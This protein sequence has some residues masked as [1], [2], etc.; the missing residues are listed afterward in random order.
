MRKEQRDYLRR[1][2]LRAVQEELGER[3]PEKA[4]VELLRQRLPEADL[5]DEVRKESERALTQLERLPPAAPDY[6]VT[7]T[8]V[9]LILELPWRKSTAD[10]IDIAKARQ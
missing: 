10:V 9:D 1:Q 8:Y 2:Q 6:Q 5:P 7:R 3:N 4:E